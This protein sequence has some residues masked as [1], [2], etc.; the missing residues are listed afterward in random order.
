MNLFE[1]GNSAYINKDRVCTIENVFVERETYIHIYI[2]KVIFAV[3][4]INDWHQQ[5]FLMRTTKSVQKTIHDIMQKI[6]T[7]R[8][9]KLH[10]H[11]RAVALL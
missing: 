7:T 5:Q 11:Y 2:Y 10:K 4:M 6:I 1:S 8:K 3:K 9:T